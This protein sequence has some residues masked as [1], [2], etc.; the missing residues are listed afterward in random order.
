MAK[1]KTRVVVGM[2][3]GVD[4]SVSALLLKEQGYDVIG[5]F[6]KNW[7]DTDD[8]GVCTATDDYED[9]KR[10]ADQIGIPY[11]SINFEKEY[12][13]RVFEYFLNEYKKGR[14][15]NPDVMCNSQ[16][17]F[18]SFLEFALN[19]D[20]DYIAMGHYAKT[21]KDKNGITHMMRPK[22]GNKDQTYFLSQLSQEQISR[23]LFPLANLT[24]PQVREIALKSGLAT[25]KKKDSTGIC[26]IGERNFRKFLSEFLP[27]QAGDMITPDGN[28]VGHHAGLMYYT[29]G[30]RSGLGLGSTKESTAP[31]FVVGKDLQKNQLI[32]QQ[33]Y[34][35]KLLYATE[36]EASDMSFFTGQ[37]E[38]DFEIHCTAKFRYRQP[39]V[40]VTVSYDAANNKAKVYFD[41]PARAVTP[42]QALVLYQGEECLGGGNIDCAYQNEQQLQL[43]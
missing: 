29:I 20:A 16:I 22:D 3:G 36:L 18:K 37:P 34:D 42:G 4:S 30:Q 26:F 7:D 14:T 35:S 31:W 12:W 28:V 40:G 13:H 15:P 33:G 23:V 8:S 32:V 2:S 41:E 21:F 27:A 6:M 39:D 43:V 24:K 25:A 9:V 1:S 38:H 11:Y 5:V 19:L 17:K 10:V